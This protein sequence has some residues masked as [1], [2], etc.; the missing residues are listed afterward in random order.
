LSTVTENVTITSV[1]AAAAGQRNHGPFR[2]VMMK[3]THE[4]LRLVWK[5][6]DDGATGD[7]K[8]FVEKVLPSAVSP[9]GNGSVPA[10]VLGLDTAE[11]AFYRIEVPAVS[12]V[13]LAPIVRMQAESL[14]PLPADRMQIAWRA[15][16]PLNGKRRCSI[17]A[18]RSDQLRNL[19]Q[20]VKTRTSRIILNAEAVVKAWT[21]LFDA[22]T[23]R[24]ILIHMRTHDTRVLLADRGVLRHAVTADVGLDDITG[25]DAAADLQLLVHDVASAV[26]LFEG[27]IHTGTPVYIIGHDVAAHEPALAALARAGINASLS[28]PAGNRLRYARQAPGDPAYASVLSGEQPVEPADIC[29]YLEPVGLAL[30]ALDG[31]PHTL[32]LFDGLLTVSDDRSGRAKLQL[33]FAVLVAAVVAILCL[34]AWKALDKAALEK[35]TDIELNSL[36]E[37]QK[38]RQLIASQRPDV[39]EIIAII[40]ERAPAGMLLDNF[41][42]KKGSPVTISTFAKSREELY[43]FEKKLDSHKD[44]SKVRTINPTLDE[45]QNRINFKMEFNYKNFSEKR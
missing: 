45:K 15:D 11:V 14:L 43:E 35:L 21:E 42:F 40:T 44:I 33:I 19:A 17:A 8:T 37:R 29:E 36:I 22:P 38:T 28:R 27:G 16:A 34:I 2:A 9:A 7:F 5:T 26:E 23:K 6:S 39:L 12:D 18:A 4:G 20:D 30:M 24:A 25:P 41:E 31:E 1:I 32:N 13:Q 3:K 10:G